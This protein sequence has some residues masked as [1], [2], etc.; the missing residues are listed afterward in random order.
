MRKFVIG[1]ILTY[2]GFVLFLLG[3]VISAISIPALD[4]MIMT[5]IPLDM[6]AA[7]MGAMIQIISGLIGVTGL[8]LCIA[9]VSKPTPPPVTI[10][11]QIPAKAPPPAPTPI[12]TNPPTPT[13]PPRTKQHM[14]VLRPLHPT[15]RILLPKL[16]PST[17]MN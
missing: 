3:F 8:L 5:L 12:P 4:N 2:V 14:Q 17:K 13:S 7:V 9:S 11:Q 6:A 10:I 1:A 15:K 16:Q